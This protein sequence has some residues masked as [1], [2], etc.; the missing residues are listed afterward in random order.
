MDTSVAP[1]AVHG[2]ARGFDGVAAWTRYLVPLAPR[3][4]R[5][6]LPVVCA[7]DGR[8]LYSAASTFHGMIQCVGR[9]AGRPFRAVRRGRFPT[10]VAGRAD[11]PEEYLSALALQFLSYHTSVVD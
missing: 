4:V 3:G 7:L 11:C 10:L 5:R 1:H 9:N 2:L 6:G 8:N